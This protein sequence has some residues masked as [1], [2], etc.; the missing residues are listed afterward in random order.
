MK[1][2]ILAGITVFLV[3]FFVT[4]DALSFSADDAVV[5]YTD[6]EY[7]EDGSSVTVYLDGSKPV[8]VTRAQRAI[9][10]N[11]A[12]MAYDYIE[13]LFVNNFG[14]AGETRA[15]SVW[16]LG[17]SAGI[18]GV[19]RGAVGGPG[20]NYRYK[21]AA[22]DGTTGNAL[23]IMFVG[24]KDNKTL[25]GIGEIL[26]VDRL[27][28]ME[29]PLEDHWD[30][31]GYPTPITDPFNATIKEE[32]T[33]VT[34]W[35]NSVKTGLLIKD[36]EAKGPTPIEQAVAYDSFEQDSSSDIRMKATRLPINNSRASYPLYPL[37]EPTK[38][39]AQNY[40]PGKEIP[41]TYE[42]GG[43]AKVFAKQIILEEGAVAEKRFPRYM[44]G[45]RYLAPTANIDTETTVKVGTYASYS[46]V[47]PLEFALTALSYGV[48]SFYIEIPVYLFIKNDPDNL[49]TT[50]A[51]NGGPD[52]VIW[53]IR[54]GLGSEL[55]SLDDG[56]SSGGC[57]L[58]GVGVTALDWLEIYWDFME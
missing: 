16:E 58:M 42:F 6:V 15:R 52:A 47:V 2:L 34:F 48:F 21:G 17:Q 28:K 31:A 49:P 54:T 12:K 26:Q 56:R 1:K 51:T 45:G 32:T 23:A 43:G 40:G 13:V 38:L 18:S 35:I 30:A 39:P 19:D 24:R 8:P 11:L 36:E 4:C 33:S 7:S 41:A 3:T 25:L 5:E 57:V 14:D 46:N 9:T 44:D 20:V 10:T 29:L 50:K 53:K 55:Y 27:P 22:T 37:P